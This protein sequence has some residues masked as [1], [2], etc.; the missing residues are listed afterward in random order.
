[1][2]CGEQVYV[3]GLAVLGLPVSFVGLLAL[4]FQ[5]PWG[6]QGPCEVLHHS[7]FIPMAI[8]HL[9]SERLN[10]SLKCGVPYFRFNKFNLKNDPFQVKLEAFDPGSGETSLDNRQILFVCQW[11]HRGNSSQKSHS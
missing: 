1:M 4:L 8:L 10:Q 5:A 9:A 2:A 7:F 3:A 11:Q 6:N